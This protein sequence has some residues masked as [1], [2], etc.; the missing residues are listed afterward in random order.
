MAYDT[1]MHMEVPKHDRA[2]L[3]RIVV[4]VVSL[5]VGATAVVAHHSFAVFDHTQTV[6]VTGTV[7]RYQWTNPHG[8][9][10]MDYRAADGST[11]HYTIELTSINMLSRAGW[12]SR[13]LKTGDMVK[14]MVAPLLSGEPGGLLLELS[15]TDGR[16]L[17]SPVPAPATFTRTR[18]R[19]FD[20][21]GC[22]GCCGG[23]VGGRRRLCDER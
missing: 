13:S 10:E 2:L 22:M 7:T 3:R 6:T 11:K 17:V 21:C 19:S 16:K 15:F 4:G 20:D 9:L 8:F 12:T 14:A 18:K 23:A 1:V 5:V